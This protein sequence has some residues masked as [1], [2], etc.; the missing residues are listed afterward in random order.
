MNTESWHFRNIVQNSEQASAR[1][2]LVIKKT[3]QQQQQQQHTTKQVCTRET[4]HV[5]VFQ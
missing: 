1:V 5:I 4:L 2:K 3:K